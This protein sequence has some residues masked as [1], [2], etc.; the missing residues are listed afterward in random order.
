MS[1]GLPKYAQVE[2]ER[3]WLADLAAA[4]PLDGLPCHTIDDLYLAGTRLRLRR[5]EDAVGGTV[6]KFCKKYG[7]EGC[8]EAITNL[9]LTEAE[10]QALSDLPGQRVRKRRYAMAGG[11]LDVYRGV[12]PL[13]IFEIEFATE[14]E[15]ADYQPPAFARIEVTH[16][17]AYSGAALAVSRGER[18]RPR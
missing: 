13:A 16:D 8:L 12:P 6:F 18:G 10:H 5:M 7:G 3:R 2:I 14:T 11:A 4:G 1:S 17:P 15:A 9:Y